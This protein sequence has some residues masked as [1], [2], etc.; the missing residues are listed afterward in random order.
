MNLSKIDFWK[1]SFFAFPLS[2]FSI[3]VACFFVFFSGFNWG[4][5]FT[6]GVYNEIV[7]KD[8]TAIDVAFIRKKLEESGIKTF[9]IQSSGKNAGGAIIK[10]TSNS[11]SD[12][13][14][15]FLDENFV[16]KRAEYIGPQ[17]TPSLVRNGVLSLFFA[18]TGVALY[19][20]IRFDFVFSMSGIIAILHDV[21]LSIGFI[22]VMQIE[23]NMITVT[24]LLTIVGYSINDSVVI[25]DRIRENI[26][27]NKFGSFRSLINHSLSSTMSRTLF[28]SI[29]TLLAT[30]PLIIFDKGVVRDFSS[31]V[32]FGVVIGTYSSVFIASF[33]LRFSDKLTKKA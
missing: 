28:T 24:A 16:Y 26:L 2:V 1:C 30:F 7:N 12:L 8:A 31:I 20:I 22:G 14:E 27:C 11:L 29:T 15:V 10:T 6:G 25:F 3:V 33:L 23:F 4:I 13:R 19:L 5:D 32:F 17:V 9:S 18:M 21:I